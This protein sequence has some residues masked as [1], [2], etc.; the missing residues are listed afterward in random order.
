MSTLALTVM[1]H[2]SLL[3]ASTDDYSQAYRR[4]VETGR[5][6]VVLIGAQWCPGCVE[7]KNNILPKVAKTGGLDGVEFAYVDADRQ[8]KIAAKLSRAQVIPQLIR[9]DKT[10]DGWK[11]QVLVGAQS[12]DKVREFLRT[13]SVSAKKPAIAKGNETEYKRAYTRSLES[14]KPLLVLLGANWCPGCVQMKNTILP[15]VA[16]AGGMKLVEF[17]YVDYDKEPEVASKLAKGGAIPQLIR[18]DRTKGGWKSRVLVGAKSPTEVEKFINAGLVSPEKA[19]RTAAKTE[20]RT[21][22]SKGS[23]W[24]TAFRLKNPLSSGRREKEAASQR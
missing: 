23:D 4:S 12:P 21:V 11:D 22:S 16:K 18:L 1:V 10:K 14:G 9:L 19:K 8:P 7:M 17:A 3:G 13:D 24:A 20:G 2:A 6:L 5:P 15:K